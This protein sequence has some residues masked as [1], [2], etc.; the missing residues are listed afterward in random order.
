MYVRINKTRHDDL[1]M[2][3]TMAMTM[4]LAFVDNIYDSTVFNFYRAV[5]DT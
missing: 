2:T 3:M 5:K 1:A 4:T